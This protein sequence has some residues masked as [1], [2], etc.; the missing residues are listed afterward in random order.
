MAIVNYRVTT[1][2]VGWKV[3]SEELL[4]TLVES[5]SVTIP[6]SMVTGL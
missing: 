1:G 5:E 6:F 4:V 2:V 3:V